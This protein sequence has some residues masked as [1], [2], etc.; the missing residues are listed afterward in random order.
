MKDMGDEF[1]KKPIGTGPYRFVEWVPGERLTVEAIP[2]KHWTGGPWVQ[3]IVWRTMTA[4]S[5]A[6]TALRVGEA[7]LMT[8]VPATEV[9][10]LTSAGVQ[11][12]YAEGSTFL[13]LILNPSAGPLAD[14]R[15]RQ[16]INYAIDKDKIIKGLFNGH[17][18]P[19]TGPLASFNEGF[20]ASA[21]V[22]YPYNPDKARQLLADAGLSGGFQFTIDTPSG[23]YVNDKQVAEAASGDLRKVGI[24]MTV[25]PM[26]WGAMIKVLQEKKS[27][28]TLLAQG[29]PDTRQLLD[30]CFSSKTRGIPWLGYANPEVDALLD[31]A[32]QEMDT[33]TRIGLFQQIS[34]TIVEDAPWVFLYQQDDSFGVRDRVQNWHPVPGG[35]LYVNG[36]S[37]EG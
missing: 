5:A 11:V 16:A 17:A 1:F 8:E 24:E 18:K 35:V 2:G 21:P 6:V 22:P 15:V 27:Q 12:Q 26:E 13:L 30:T 14:K 9:S 33:P 28:A 32:A 23:R 4:P 7:D 31:K 25:N 3:K 19:L 10:A 29:N 36:V 20:D 37:V 34:K